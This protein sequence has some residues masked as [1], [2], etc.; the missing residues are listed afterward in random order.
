MPIKSFADRLKRL[1]SEEKISRRSLAAQTGLQ[2]K[3]IVNWLAGKYYPRYD[4][5]IK[6]ADFFNVKTDYL[7]GLCNGNENCLSESGR[8][9]DVPA[10]FKEKLSEFLNDNNMTKYALAKKLKIGQT[11][12]Q[13]WFLKESMPETA[14]L[15]KLAAIME[16]SV[17]F[18]LGRE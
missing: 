9:R 4:A 18:L 8:A 10:Q 1:M 2:R 14:K 11:T 7:L 13:R 5:L 16:E 17:D 3:S 15:I 6:L 12:L